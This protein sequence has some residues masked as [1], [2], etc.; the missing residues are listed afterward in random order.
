MPTIRRLLV[1]STEDSTRLSSWSN[2]PYLFCKTLEDQ[3]L[4][5][6][7]LTLRP[8]GVMGSAVRWA[9]RLLKFLRVR[10][11]ST[12]DYTRSAHYY[13]RVQRQIDLALER[14]AFDGVLVLNFSYGPSLPP[15]VPLYLFC[16]W[17]LSYAIECQRL[18]RPGSLERASILRENRLINAASAVFVLFPLAERFVRSA[19]P[20]ARTHYLGN[21]IN[22]VEGPDEGDIKLKQASFSLL[23]VGKPHYREGALQLIDAYRQLKK[24]LPTLALNIVGMGEEFFGHLPEGV[25]CHGYLDKGDPAQREKYYGLLRRARLF[26]NPNPKWASFS[27]ALEAMYFYTPVVTS[28]YAEMEETFGKDISFGAYYR[29]DD[30]QPLCELLY[31]LMS[32]KDYESMARNAH[33]EASPFSWDAYVKRVLNV[34]EMGGGSKKII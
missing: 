29:A 18:R 28:A 24:A 2:V 11:E 14:E 22:A 12:W 34:I 13:W 16:D 20:Q 27:A 21:V 26:V 30:T 9:L 15:K 10:K 8:Q 7:R 31:R 6:G 32:S 1:V 5:L 25:F 19:L 3:G 23:F 17:S 4:E 33:I